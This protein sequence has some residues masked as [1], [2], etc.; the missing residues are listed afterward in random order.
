MRS[1]QW[2]KSRIG[3]CGQKPDGDQYEEHYLWIQKIV[4]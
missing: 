1:L 4:G 3:R 2:K